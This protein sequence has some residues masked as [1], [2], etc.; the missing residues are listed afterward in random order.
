[1]MVVPSGVAF[2]TASLAMRPIAPG[3]FS[4]I[5][6]TPRLSLSLSATTR[7]IRSAVPPAGNPTRM[8]TGLSNFSCANAVGAVPNSIALASA[9]TNGNVLRGLFT[10]ASWPQCCGLLDSG[11]LMKMPVMRRRSGVLDGAVLADPAR[12]R[13]PLLPILLRTRARQIE[14]R[15]A[16]ARAVHVDLRLA[17]V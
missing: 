5:T 9:K 16:I 17:Q 11:W 3:R 12:Q 8:R 2:F 1:M 6:G 4:T 14:H 13:T 15:Q 10:I 7:A